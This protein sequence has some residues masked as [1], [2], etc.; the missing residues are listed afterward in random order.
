MVK[1]KALVAL[2]ILFVF[3]CCGSLA[4]LSRRNPCRLFNKSL[5]SSPSLFVIEAATR[6][7]TRAKTA[8]TMLR[9][10]PPM[11]TS[12]GAA[13]GCAPSMPALGAAHEVQKPCEKGGGQER[14]GAVR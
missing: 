7:G 5:L 6:C 11:Q 12:R 8:Q 3:P 2:G 10:K 9:K 4:S 13:K 14:A 1:K